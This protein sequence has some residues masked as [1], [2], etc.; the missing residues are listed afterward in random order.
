MKIAKSL[1]LT[2]CC[3]FICELAFAQPRIFHDSRDKV[4]VSV[5]INP[6]TAVAGSDAV[7][8]ITLN[9]E[10]HW[11]THTNDPQ[12]PEDLGDPEDYIA[13]SIEFD[14]PDGSPLTL[15]AGYIQWP[16]P[17]IVEVGFTGTP[18]DY[19]VFSDEVV[20]YIPVTISSDAKIGKTSLTIK[21][22]FQVCDET[23]C[24]RATPRPGESSWKEYGIT[25]SINIAKS[26][27][28]TTSTTKK[29]ENFDGSVFS[30]IHSGV[31][32]PIFNIIKFDAFGIK[33]DI[34]TSGPL[35][36]LL[37]LLVAM[38]GGFLL[39]LTPCVLP[40]IPIKIMGL[41]ASAGNRRKT[42]YLGVWMMLGV[43]ALW[44][45]LGVGIALVT[46]FTA[47]NQL[48]QY[49]AFTI[50]LG[51]FIGIMAIGMGGLFSIRLPN[52]VYKVNPKHDSWFGSFLFGVM[53]AVLST[54]C[55]AP[56]M[57]AAAAWAATQSATITLS[58]FGS[59][60]F[61][62]A[63]PYLILAMFPHLVEKMPR[64]GAASEVIK[65]VMGLLMLAAAAYFLG[66]GLSGA[67]QQEGAPPS[68]VYLWIVAAC[69]AASG[70]WLTWR[71]LRIAKTATVK[72]IFVLLGLCIIGG[73]IFG[74][75]RLTDKGPI[76][77]EYYT[78][79][80]L[81]EKLAE[82]DIVVLEFTAEWCLNCKLLES[83]VLHSPRVVDAFDADDV[84]P[85]KIDLT[86]NNV[87]GNELLNELGGLRIPLL[88]IMG[89]DGEEE[90]RGD[91]YT[92]DQVLGAIK[93]SRGTSGGNE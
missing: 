71:T 50:I 70:V 5:H 51:A 63:V 30:A 49:P 57:G 15:H 13:T 85:I 73:G 86:G 68:R 74:G 60:G 11:H 88:I 80:L 22:I 89:P 12:V 56:F 26:G 42:L 58:V 77:W 41:S 47:I 90:F 39:N 19:G 4:S 79:E 72:F 34:D 44:V 10:E 83:T 7:I 6:E 33:F 67:M 61:G 35:G 18:V 27:N 92:V 8:A 25:E 31:K 45:L 48:F 75:I 28:T 78:P 21:P 9:H 76:D 16:T 3:L 20:I 40:V 29:F 84:S 36:L 2:Y 54:P 59:I 64:A 53:T 66:V 82:G 37:L 23:T 38:G 46:G 62:M 81:A 55:T 69:V 52:A 43:M 17:T 65:Q 87:S 24:L 32:A 1:L 91:F 93:K 14:L